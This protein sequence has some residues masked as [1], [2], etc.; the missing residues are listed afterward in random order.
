MVLATDEPTR[1]IPTIRTNIGAD[2]R[3]AAV[4][5]RT[6]SP[7]PDGRPPPRVENLPLARA[8]RGRGEQH[9]ARRLPQHVLRHRPDLSFARAPDAP[10]NR[11]APNRRGDR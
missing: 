8:G 9:P 10:E 3:P 2:S 11:A 6:R 7:L 4:D 1:P 5:D